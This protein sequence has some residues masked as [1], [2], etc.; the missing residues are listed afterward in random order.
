MENVHNMAPESPLN[1]VVVETI[2]SPQDVRVHVD[3]GRQ[4]ACP[5]AEPPPTRELC[6]TRVP[7]SQPASRIVCHARCSRP[8]HH[9]DDSDEDLDDDDLDEENDDDHNDHNNHHQQQQQHHQQQH[10]QHHHHHQNNRGHQHQQHHQNQHHQ[11]HHHQQHHQNQHHPHQQQQQQHHHQ[12]ADRSPVESNGGGSRRGVGG[13]VVVRGGCGGGGGGGSSVIVEDAKPPESTITVIVHHPDDERASRSSRLNTRHSVSVAGMIEAQDYHRGS[14]SGNNS[15]LQLHHQQQ[16]QQQQQQP[17]P[18]YQTL[19]SVN[20]RMSPPGY[21]PNSSYATLTPL[22]PLPPISTMSDKFVYGHSN[23]VSGSFTVMQNNIGGMGMVVN[24]PYTYEKLGMHSPN[25]YSPTHMHHMPQQQG[26]PISPQSAS[27]SQNGGGGGGGGGLNSPQK[28]MSS[29]N[30]CYDSP[31]TQIGPGGR[32]GGGNA[33]HSPDMSQN[34]G[35]LHSPPMSSYGGTTTL[36]NVN[37]LT[38]ITPHPGRGGGGG[39]VVSPRHSPSLVIHPIIQPQEVV[40]TTSSP[41]PPD[42]S[43][44]MQMMH[45]QQLQQQQTT[46]IKT[47]SITTT[48]TVLVQNASSAS[49]SN[50]SGS[51]MEEINTKELAQRISAELKRYSIPQAIF[52]QRV[53]CRSQGTLSDLLRNPKPWSKLKSGRETFRRMWKWLQEPEFQRMS[54]LRLA[55]THDDSSSNLGQDLEGMLLAENGLQN[56][57]S[58]NVGNYINNMVAQIPLQNPPCKRKEESQPIIPDHSTAPKKPRLVFTDL[59]RRTLQAIFKETKRPS[60]EM[61]VTIARQLGLEPTTVGNFFM[62]A[63]RR[64]MDKWKDEDPKVIAAS[65]HHQ[66][67]IVVN[68]QTGTHM[69]NHQSEVL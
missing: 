10:H 59:Q 8:V 57:T 27:Y 1:E 53:L 16:Q 63:R 61:Q 7:R 54:A 46:L 41:S 44:R 20:G 37:G 24:S 5:V 9:D 58:P 69:G 31:Y 65:N 40:V 55:G 64:S 49:G 13:T 52:A 62:N 2:D 17:E 56:V 43:Q 36:S 19:T 34:S 47:Q 42:H 25:H 28:S 67:D 51:D 30:S 3:A 18:T 15:V 38:T 35:S 60:K 26:S 32:S 48:T 4:S 39:V 66:D 23:N 33:M 68:M 21:S 14:G 45:Q 6:I 22:Q 50:G 11:A 12:N 29:P